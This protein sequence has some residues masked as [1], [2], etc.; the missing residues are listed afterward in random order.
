MIV[1]YIMLFPATGIQFWKWVGNSEYMATL[2]TM[3]LLK[4]LKATL[5]VWP[6]LIN[7]GFNSAQAKNWP[8][9]TEK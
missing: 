8:Y 2:D 4:T 6:I 5:E 1:N 7:P 3:T 9:D